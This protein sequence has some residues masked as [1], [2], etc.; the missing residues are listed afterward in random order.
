MISTAVSVN[1]TQRD[2]S[3]A[4]ME[5]TCI[6]PINETLML[7]VASPLNLPPP[8]HLWRSSKWLKGLCINLHPSCHRPVSQQL[9]VPHWI[10]E[11]CSLG[12]RGWMRWWSET[13]FAS[14]PSNRSRLGPTS[15]THPNL[16]CFC[17]S[18]LSQGLRLL[19]FTSCRKVDMKAN[20]WGLFG[21]LWMNG[22]ETVEL[23]MYCCWCITF[24]GL[25]LQ[26]QTGLSLSCTCNCQ[27]LL[28][29]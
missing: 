27:W 28:V 3:E 6:F 1:V 12:G 8:P 2:S 18:I 4:N 15:V 26:V 16:L 11:R 13:V 20:T 7:R 23:L 5:K 25:Y 22:S 17:V 29:I 14:P 24:T 19:T 10:A 21:Y 9:P